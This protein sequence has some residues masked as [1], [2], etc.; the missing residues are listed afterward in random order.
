MAGAPET[1]G[2]NG[3]RAALFLDR[4]GTLIA[5]AGY[6][7]DPA[8]VR[9]LPGV[10][11]ALALARRTHRLFLF[12][13]QSGIARGL[14]GWEAVDAVNRR[15][16]ELL[17]LPEPL[18]EAFC[19]APEHPGETA[20][21]RKPSPRF[22]LEC[23]DHFGLDPERC[24]MVGDRLSDLRAGI[25]A[26]VRAALIS[27]GGE[28]PAADLAAYVR[29]HGIPVHASLLEFARK[30][31]PARDGVTLRPAPARRAEP[32]PPGRGR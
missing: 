29:L 1:G 11:R 21:Y 22:I 19:A 6:L 13:N 7:A 3:R 27:A 31:M 14:F 32:P 26:G 9:L 16:L 23:I 24:W 20:V 2:G 8:G 28:A 5:D 30:T 18:F 15:L 12:S 10:R 4:D 17:R 25:R